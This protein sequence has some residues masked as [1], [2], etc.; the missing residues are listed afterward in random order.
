MDKKKIHQNTPKRNGKL[1]QSYS[2]SESQSQ[3]EMS[4]QCQEEDSQPEDM[5]TTAKQ[6]KLHHGNDVSVT[7][8]NM[9][10]VTTAEQPGELDD[11]TCENGERRGQGDATDAVEKLTDIKAVTEAE[12][13]K[14]EEQ[15]RVPEF[16][17]T[18]EGFKYSFNESKQK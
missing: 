12:E 14:V 6:P 1:S 18:L 16:P 11:D 8:D 3:M 5:A 9:A 10:S 7:T 4:Q 13:Q 17:D 15:L 2:N